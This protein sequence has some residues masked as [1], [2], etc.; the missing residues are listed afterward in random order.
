MLSFVISDFCETG[1]RS[2]NTLSGGCVTTQ[3]ITPTKF[4][5]MNT[6]CTPQ[7]VSLYNL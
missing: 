7:L 3:E 6:L 1:L 4:S 5:L 2:S